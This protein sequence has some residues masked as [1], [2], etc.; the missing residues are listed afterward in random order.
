[1]V[2]V[3]EQSG[4]GG[5]ARKESAARKQLQQR[6]RQYRKEAYERE[7]IVKARFAANADSSVNL[8]MPPNDR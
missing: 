3:T 2:A 7:K 6:S 4:A 1:L 8:R 5:G